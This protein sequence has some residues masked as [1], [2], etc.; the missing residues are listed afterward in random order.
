MQL[1]N[2]KYKINIILALFMIA[3]LILQG[4]TT[5]TKEMPSSDSSK[6]ESELTIEGVIL[7]NGTIFV[8]KSKSNKQ[9]NHELITVQMPDNSE[10]KTP[11][12][13]VEF[14]I[15][16]EI[17]D[18]YPMQATGLM[19][20]VLQNTTGVIKGP[21]NIGP[22]ILSHMPEDAYFIDVRT[23]EEFASGHIPESTNLPLNDLESLITTEI[24]DKNKTILIYCRSG[25]RSATAGKI[26]KDLNYNIVFDLGGINDFEG[27]IVTEIHS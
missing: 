22:N 19:S 7:T 15:K 1:N 2:K 11:G 5:P 17:R 21:I 12:A 4:C 20:K 24:P 10:P 6:I 25:N 23:P 13:L 26:L 8:T 3:F 27:D 9:L 18:S 16:S 14:I